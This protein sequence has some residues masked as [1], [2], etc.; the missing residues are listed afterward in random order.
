MGSLHRYFVKSYNR[1]IVFQSAGTQYAVRSPQYVVC[2]RKCEVRST[3]YSVGSATHAV[4]C[5]EICNKI[6]EV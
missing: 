4:L 1:E 6:A 2:I 5:I 3:Q